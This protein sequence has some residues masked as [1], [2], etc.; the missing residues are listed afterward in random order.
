MTK[1][2]ARVIASVVT[3]TLLVG[4]SPLSPISS[5]GATAAATCTSSVGPGIPPPTNVPSGQDGFHASWYGQSGYPTLCPGERSTATV[6]YYNS[7]SRG[8]VANRMGEM[9]FLGTWDPSPGQ[10]KASALGGD[11][12]AGS[13]NTGWPR[14]NRV[15]AQP[16]S[17]VGPGQIAWF[18]FTIVA[19]SS[20]G[21]HKLYIRPLIEGATWMEDFGVY[22]QVTVKTTDPEYGLLTG[23]GDSVV[24]RSEAD[25][26]PVR[27]F[28]GPVGLGGFEARD[29]SH[30]G[31]RLAYWTETAGTAELHV[32][33]LSGSDTIVARFANLRRG[34]IAWAAGDGG[35]LV[36]LAEPRQ[37]QFVIPRIVIAVDLA[38]GQTREIHRGTG[39]SGASVIPLAWRRSPEVF[40]VYETGPGGLNFGY[41]VIKPGAATMT[42]EPDGSVIL[43]QA[44]SDGSQV[45]GLWSS[46]S[47]IRV[48]PV[49]NFANQ[50]E[51]R[52]T[53]PEQIAQARWWPDLPEVVY[54]R[55]TN[56][57][58]TFRSGRIERWNP[59]T[60]GHS[61]VRTLEP[62]TALGGYH[63]RADG[64]GVLI[65][66]ADGRWEVTE[67]SSGQTTVVP[68]V[69]NEQLVY[70]VTLK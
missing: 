51:F 13:P 63:V 54:A 52:V 15:A 46:R 18:Q 28:A 38:S 41:T 11:G 14:Y 55:A 60:G 40:A 16:A 19:P 30:D 2:W 68:T 29:R 20:P 27:T 17:Y 43:M 39:P 6:A 12:A 9:A 33:E 37:D 58:G 53:A 21:I 8:W 65:Q 69:P 1:V 45:L 23:R 56:D 62:S 4:I 61:Q 10:D 59:T 7:G 25:V 26:S 49:D 57:G 48:W 50:V 67:L 22:W 36:S 44:S 35:I 31:R 64:S 3:L 34:G 24:V 42:W 47:A 66:K 70:G 32:L 5:A